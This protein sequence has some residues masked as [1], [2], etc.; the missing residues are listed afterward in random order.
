MHIPAEPADRLD[1]REE[2]RN[3]MIS[4]A[5]E[6]DEITCLA[7]WIC[8]TPI[9]LVTLTDAT[10]HRLAS[11]TGLDLPS[12]WLDTCFS[13]HTVQ[14]RGV[15]LI[16]DAA[17]D[18]RVAAAALVAGEP[19]I[20]FYAGVPLLDG[21]GPPVGTLGVLD[22][23][24]RPMSGKQQAA[25]QMLGRQVV[26]Q[27][28]LGRLRLKAG[29]MRMTHASQAE[30]DDSTAL[31]DHV[32]FSQRVDEECQ[33]AARYLRPLSLLLISVSPF[34]G[35][36]DQPADEVL[37]DAVG[38]WLGRSARVTDVVGRL[39]KDEFAVLLTDTGHAGAL[40]LSER[41]RHIVAWG[42]WEHGPVLVHVSVVSWTVGGDASTL[43]QQ[44]R[45]A[46]H[47]SRELG[48]GASVSTVS[49]K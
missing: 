5:S 19:H 47:H 34:N 14:Q 46:L 25:L 10:G 31:Q 1:R 29:Q 30:T 20:R 41:F 12:T 23:L 26:A 17:T 22:R 45:T 18:H 33:R 7:A 38:H 37:L 40:V 43:L 27:L 48:V 21:P 4:P 44:A 15:L 49:V 13:T 2:T 9:A 42:G 11:V 39:T 28:E 32:A 6:I 16:P 24:A 8:E 35:S 36:R 3:A